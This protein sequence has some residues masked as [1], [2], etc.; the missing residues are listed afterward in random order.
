MAAVTCHREH[1][2]L[3]LVKHIDGMVLI[4]TMRPDSQLGR[5]LF[6]QIARMCL[7]PQANFAPASCGNVSA[8]SARYQ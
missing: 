8:M 2:P 7:L 6:D 1:D 5:D 3:K 4:N